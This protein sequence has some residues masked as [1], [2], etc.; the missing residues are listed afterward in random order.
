MKYITLN[1]RH[2]KVYN[3]HIVLLNHF[4]FRRERVNIP[5]FVRFSM[6]VSVAKYKVNPNLVP[7]H[8]IV[9][10]LVYKHELT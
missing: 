9:M 4:H 1:G 7:L 2:K 5:H 6:G 3:A 8:H 10:L